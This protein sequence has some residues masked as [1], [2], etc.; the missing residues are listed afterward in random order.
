MPPFKLICLAI[1]TL[2]AFAGNSV[3]NRYALLQGGS[4]AWN[5]ALIR[6]VAGAITLAVLTGFRVKSGNWSGGLSLL[7]YAVFFSFAYLVLDAGLGALILFTFVQFTMLGRG[8]FT[9]ER[10]TPPQWAGAALAFIAMAW[11]L[12]PKSNALIT[13]PSIYWALIAMSIAGVSWGAYSLI[14]RS[15]TDPLKETSG[16]FARAALLALILTVPITL[17]NPEPI[18]ALP[19]IIA[20]ILSGAVTSALGYAIWYAILPQLSRIQ[21]G[22]MQL[23]VPA[24]AAFGGVLFLDEHLTQRLVICTALILLGVGIATT[25]QKSTQIRRNFKR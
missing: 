13:S 22:V 6:L 7:A 8:V 25:P 1:L 4:E 15:A 18:P 9:G 20:A 16:N 11:L 24:I 12:W 19:V 3:L 10:L 23:S 21:A 14:G 2:L 5:F 17:I